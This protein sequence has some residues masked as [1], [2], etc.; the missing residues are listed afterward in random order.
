MAKYFSKVK[1]QLNQK[2][3]QK[4]TGADVK[5]ISDFIEYYNNIET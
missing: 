5:S 4:K 3:K 1:A 2:Q